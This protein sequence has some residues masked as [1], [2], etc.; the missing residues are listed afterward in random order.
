MNTPFSTVLAELAH[1][2]W[3]VELLPHR[4]SLPDAVVRRYP[5]MPADYR[6]VIEEANLITSPDDKA[7]LLT[8]ADFSGTANCAYAWNEWE[9]QSLEAAGDDQDWK[10]RIEQFWDR[11][12]PIMMSVKSGYAYLAIE[13]TSLSVV[14]GEDPEYEETSLVAATIPDALRLLASRDPR[15]QR[16]G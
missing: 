3:K 2:G 15:V 10:S 6:E 4:R 8:F 16:W 14:A 5:W 9:R 13:R 11:H 12:F 7:W 1:S